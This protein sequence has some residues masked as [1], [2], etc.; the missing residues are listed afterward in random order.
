M[1]ANRVGKTYSA[2]FEVA[3]VMR[4]GCTQ[5]GGTAPGSTMHLRSG[6]WVSLVSRCAT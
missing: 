3:R 6:A 1:A 2:A 4:P 5:S